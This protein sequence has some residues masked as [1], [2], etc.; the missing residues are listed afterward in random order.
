MLEIPTPLGSI[1]LLQADGRLRI[2]VIDDSVGDSERGFGAKCEADLE[3]DD[4]AI[5][6]NWLLEGA[7][8]TK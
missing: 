3:A 5:L 4:I 7:V 2:T 6:V 8:A 1:E